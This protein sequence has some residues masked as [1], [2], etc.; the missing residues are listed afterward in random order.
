MVTVARPVE[1]TSRRLEKI[2]RRFAAQVIGVIGSC[3][4]FAAVGCN[5]TNSGNES[6][7]A[8]LKQ[9]GETRASL[10]PLAGKVTIDGEP[11]HFVRP[12][13]LIVMLNDPTNPDLS[14]RPC[15]QCD[16][17]GEFAFGTYTKGD[18]LPA[19]KFIVTFAVLRVTARGLIG[20]DQ[21]KNLYNDP[22]KNAKIPEFNIVH[23][24]PGKKDYVFD[25]K[26]AGQEAVETPGPNALTELRPQRR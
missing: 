9:S 24:A 22:D 23:Q 26:I 7:E 14:K 17:E 10:Y 4:A 5:G 13:R 2:V 15:R 25:L 16:D 18:G 8:L 11:P 12:E 6:L 21:L 3:A 20:P 1:I 19:G